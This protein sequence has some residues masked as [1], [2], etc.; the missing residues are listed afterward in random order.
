MK[1]IYQSENSTVY[2]CTIM[3]YPCSV[4]ET[5]DGHVQIGVPMG[6]GEDKKM[7]DDLVYYHQTLYNGNDIKDVISKVRKFIIKYK[8][9]NAKTNKTKNSKN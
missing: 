3:G 5:S 9:L 1:K 8:K 4:R 7:F 2:E 6:K